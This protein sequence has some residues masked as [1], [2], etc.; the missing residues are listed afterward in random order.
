MILFNSIRLE[1]GKKM[2]DYEIRS[3]D[4][5]CMA[6]NLEIKPIVFDIPQIIFP[7]KHSI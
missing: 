1:D 3:G 7:K 2:K 5:L 6:K 4:F